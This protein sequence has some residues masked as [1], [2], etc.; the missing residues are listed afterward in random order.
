V[1]PA[2]PR[3]ELAYLDEVGMGA[4]VAHEATLTRRFLDGVAAIN[5][6]T[7]HGPAEADGRTPTFALTVDGWT[8]QAVAE[9]LGAEGINVWAGHY[10]ALEPMRALGLLDAGGRA[11]G[12]RRAPARVRRHR[13]LRHR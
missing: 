6:V 8:P 9:T 13:V 5:H 1:H 7:L 2:R 10:Y 11:D 4:I 12:G 3:R